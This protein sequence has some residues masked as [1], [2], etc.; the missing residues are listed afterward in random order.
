MTGIFAVAFIAAVIISTS[1]FVIL[2]GHLQKHRKTEKRQSVFNGLSDEFRLSIS[3][4][5]VF[6]DR[7]IGLDEANRNLLFVAKEDD[8]HIVDLDDVKSATVKKEY[9]LV[10]DGYTRRKGAQTGVK[11]IDVELIYWNR[12]VPVVLSLYDDENSDK[13]SREEAI[14]LAGKWEKLIS[15][16]LAKHD[17][18]T[19]MY[20]P[21][22]GKMNVE[23]A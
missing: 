13:I 18:A 1:L 6:G 2:I 22:S 16:I 7:I 5:D 14:E 20:Q 3:K 23:R 11:R 4:Q 12:T 10:F 21:S 17:A 9:G 8:G 15:G 19:R